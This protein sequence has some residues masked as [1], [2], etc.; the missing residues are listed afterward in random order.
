MDT[1][2]L[3]SLRLGSLTFAEEKAAENLPPHIRAVFDAMK[4]GNWRTLNM[5]VFK[6][7]GTRPNA[8]AR[9]R[10]LRKPQYGGHVVEKK[11]VRKG[12]WQYR[13]LVGEWWLRA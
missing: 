12:V 7:G 5:I 6:V 2:D 3:N 1:V 8:A 13:L 10:D 9:L 11:V 4:D